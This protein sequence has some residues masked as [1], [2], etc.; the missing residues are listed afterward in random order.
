MGGL[1]HFGIVETSPQRKHSQ[2][3]QQRRYRLSGGYASF[4]GVGAKGNALDVFAELVVNALPGALPW[5]CLGFSHQK[6][7]GY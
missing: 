7:Y 6:A 1:T 4:T 5:R 2:G 3:W